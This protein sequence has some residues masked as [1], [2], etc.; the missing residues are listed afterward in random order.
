MR[1]AIYLRQSQDRFGDE[2]A[3]TRQREDC[4]KL[5]QG[6]GWTPTEYLDNDVSASTGKPRPAYLRMIADI[7]ADKVDAV[8]AWDADR[9]HRRPIELEAFI[10][11]ADQKH[12]ALATWGGDFDLSTPT[13]RGNA[14][15]KGVFA[16]MEMEQ[17]SARQKR[18][19]KQQAENGK[20]W[21]A[22]R[23]F[24]YTADPDPVGR[25]TSKNPIRLHPVESPLVK[26]A[27][28]A[29]MTGTALYRVAAEWNEAGVTRPTGGPWRGSTVRVLLLAGRNAGLREHL[30]KVIGAGDWPAIV[31][32]QLW[33]GVSALLS[34]PK[35]GGR[36]PRGRT[37]LLSGIA[38]CGECKHT[39][40][41]GITRTSG[42]LTYVCKECGQ[43]SRA[44]APIDAMVI[45]AVVARLSREDAVE[46]TRRDDA[47]DADELRTR[48]EAL[49]AQQVA[50]ARDFTEGETSYQFAATVDRQLR[51]QIEAIDAQLTDA[52]KAHVFDGLIGVDDVDAAFDALD[53]GRQRAVVNA[54][55]TVVVRRAGR[56]RRF[57]RPVRA[58]GR[59]DID[60]QFIR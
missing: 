8:V 37:R 12:L 32:E 20:P 17:K 7:K 24:G 27:Y 10:D 26:A 29:V 18:A 56:G 22:Q 4:L 55:V 45:E 49:R 5:C 1:A 39:L 30:G 15:M 23:P 44:A 47:P 50:A 21:W 60:I 9:L 33:R 34:D 13:G 19:A 46:L 16:R 25:W 53:L 59:D 40:G 31:D 35:R 42:T 38:R 57:D 14:R 48:R 6:R 2:M 43:V 3:V 51:Q 28:E 11:L 41:G 54:L 58:N 52:A 36:A